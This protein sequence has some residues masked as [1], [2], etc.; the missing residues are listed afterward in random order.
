M[1]WIMPITDGFTAGL[2]PAP[3]LPFDTKVILTILPGG[4]IGIGAL[5]AV[6]GCGAL[7][8]E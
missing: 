4:Y 3:T 6:T 1:T 5:T 7:M 2:L 8:W